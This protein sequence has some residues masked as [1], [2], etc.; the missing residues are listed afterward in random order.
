M[1]VKPFKDMSKNV[2][3]TLNEFL[4]FIIVIIC[5]FFL[6]REFEHETKEMIGFVLI[7]TI[8]GYSAITLV[9]IYYL[10]IKEFCLRRFKKKI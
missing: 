7:F 2:T 1:S 6:T 5:L 10:N 9:R 3:E 4:I 8:Y